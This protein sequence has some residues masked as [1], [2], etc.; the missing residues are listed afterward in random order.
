MV[1]HRIA[2]NGTCSYLIKRF[3]D[4]G[5]IDYGFAALQ[6]FQKNGL[7]PERMLRKFLFQGQLAHKN[8]IISL[9]HDALASKDKSL[10]S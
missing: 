7:Q 4:Q 8:L 10:V 2:D 9:F 6:W 1:R 5:E 3:C